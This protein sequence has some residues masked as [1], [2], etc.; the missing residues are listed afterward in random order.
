[1]VDSL[2][3]TLSASAAGF[4]MFVGA[5]SSGISCHVAVSLL[6]RFEAIKPIT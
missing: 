6:R 5:L 3:K 1:M 4:L 2:L